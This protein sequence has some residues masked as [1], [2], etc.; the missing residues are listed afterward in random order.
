MSGPCL[1]GDPYCPSCGNPGAAEL[2]ATEEWAME[3]MS[4]A[5]L[6]PDEYRL[7]VTVGL[8]VV[9]ECRKYAETVLKDYQAV[10]AEA[11]EAKLTW[12]DDNEQRD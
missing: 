7:V 6:T 1:C 4:K 10:L 3:E 12:T 9:F 5:Q 2:E 8:A 11:A